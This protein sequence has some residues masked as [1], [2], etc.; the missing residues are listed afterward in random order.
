MVYTTII[1]PII[2][3]QPIP[4]PPD[5]DADGIPDWH[6]LDSDNDLIHDVEEGGNAIQMMML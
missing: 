5:K 6:D 2:T 4:L 3:N 1:D